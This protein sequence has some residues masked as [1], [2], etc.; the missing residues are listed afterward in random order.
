MVLAVGCI[1]GESRLSRDSC[2]VKQLRLIWSQSETPCPQIQ[3][4]FSPAVSAKT[5]VHVYRETTIE[6]RVSSAGLK[7]RHARILILRQSRCGKSQDGNSHIGTHFS[8]WEFPHRERLKM[9][10]LNTRLKPGH[11]RARNASRSGARAHRARTDD[12]AT[13]PLIGAQSSARFRSSHDENQSSSA[14]VPLKFGRYLCGW[15]LR[16]TKQP[17]DRP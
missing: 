3:L 10:R 14:C 13:Y 12:P 2:P 17:Q 6:T 16:H 15:Q 7:S 11:N 5:T 8:S 1:E 9:G 4:C